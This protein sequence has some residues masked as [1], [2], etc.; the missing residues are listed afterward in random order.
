MLGAALISTP[1]LAQTYGLEPITLEAHAD[2]ADYASSARMI[3]HLPLP[4][5]SSHWRLCAVFPHIKDEYWLSVDYGM[6]EEARRLGVALNVVETGGYNSAAA[7]AA[8]L[9]RCD[10]DAAILGTVSYDGAEVLSAIRDV[11]RRMPVIAAVNDVASAD[12]AVKIGV[13]WR[14]M[15]S[16][17]G[18]WLSQR[19]PSGS[20]PQR[21]VLATGPRTAGWVSVLSRGLEEALRNSSVGIVE[22]GWADTGAQQQLALAEDLLERNGSIDYFIGSAPAA[23][24]V[25]SL[26]MTRG[27]APAAAVVATYYTQAIRRGM[28][29]GHIQAAPFDDPALQGRLAVEYAVRAIEGAVDHRQLGP[30]VVLA[31][32]DTLPPRAALAP[33]D[34][35]PVFVLP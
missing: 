31:T 1:C 22:T 33:A 4:R 15:G 9:R 14:E 28:M 24:A 5:A 20:K 21:A 10:G 8:A 35:R 19:H 2:A 32:K 26:M 7:Q 17:L 3:N 18:E 12:V 23:E 30:P 29:R 16:A 13:S 25:V 27:T 34:F 6:V 11:S